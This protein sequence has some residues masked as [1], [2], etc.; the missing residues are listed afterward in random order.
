M[1]RELISTGNELAALAAIDSKCEFFGGY[2]ITHLVKLC[3]HYHRNYLQ[4]V[5]FV[6]KW[7][8]KFLE[9]VQVLVQL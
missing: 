6:C 3:I 2:P 1:S 8:M 5:E 9:F 7:K 4:L